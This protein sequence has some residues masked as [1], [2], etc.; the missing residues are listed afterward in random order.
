MAKYAKA[1]PKM[2]ELELEKYV[3]E[4]VVRNT[5]PSY[6]TAVPLV[7]ALARLP[8]GTYATFPAEVLR[9]SKN[10]IK[11]SVEDIKAGRASI[12][13]G[14]EAGNKELIKAGEELTKIGRDRLTSLSSL[15]VGVSAAVAANNEA[16]GVTDKELRAIN[17]V[18]PDFS[19]TSSKII[20]SPSRS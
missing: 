19:T 8:L 13:A 12:N 11:I 17:L 9:T 16:M 5:M 18:V 10:I 1:F 7:R 15:V 3:A 6:S 20:T 2:S 4:R 14:K